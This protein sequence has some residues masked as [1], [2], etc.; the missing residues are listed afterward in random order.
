MR[1]GEREGV[2]EGEIVFSGVLSPHKEI[3]F[4]SSD[5]MRRWMTGRV[6]PRCIINTSR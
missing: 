5:V 3:P 1:E 6:A 4:R 2:R